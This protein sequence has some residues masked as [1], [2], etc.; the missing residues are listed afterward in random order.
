MIKNLKLKNF[1]G[2]KEGALDFA[3]ITILIGPNNSGKTTI[4]EALLLAPNPFRQVPY[5][6]PKPYNQ[7]AI[8]VISLLPGTLNTNFSKSGIDIR[9]AESMII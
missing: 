7:M 1:K 6:L 3:P 2:I 9:M 4:L 5:Q 8:D